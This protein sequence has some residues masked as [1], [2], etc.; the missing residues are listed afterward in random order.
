MLPVIIV[1]GTLIFG[2]KKV[3][4]YFK[5]DS[6]K[7]IYEEKV[8]SQNDSGKIP[9]ESE[10]VEEKENEL[11]DIQKDLNISLTSTV[12]SGIGH[13]YFAPFTSLAILGLGYLT[14]MD[15]GKAHGVWKKEKKSVLN[16]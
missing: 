9:M 10:L 1:A 16:S 5:K 2:R 8:S 15:M 6:Q 14:V 11:T 3:V 7:S 12:F 4:A 13:L